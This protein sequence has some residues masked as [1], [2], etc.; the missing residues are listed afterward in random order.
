MCV[1]TRFKTE[2]IHLRRN[3]NYL[4]DVTLFLYIAYNVGN[5][6]TELVLWM[7]DRLTRLLLHAFEQEMCGY[8]GPIYATHPTK[9]IM[10]ILLEVGT[11]IKRWRVMFL[12]VCGDNTDSIRG[13]HAVWMQ[14]SAWYLSMHT[15]VFVTYIYTYLHSYVC[16]RSHCI[17]T[18]QPYVHMYIHA[19]I[20]T[21]T[22]SY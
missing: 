11:F 8:D 19:Y 6:A 12:F 13:R 17:I 3:F 15:Y 4:Q 10:P 18:W 1:H 20:Y 7:H 22:Q 21:Y 16:I 2:G 9:A 5:E 14:T